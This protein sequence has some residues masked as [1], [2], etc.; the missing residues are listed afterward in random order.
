[1]YVRI[2]QFQEKTGSELQKAVSKWLRDKP[3][4]GLILDLRNNPGGVLSAAVDVVNTFVSSGLIVYTEG[5]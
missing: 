3:V 1:G 2:T 4:N 5:R